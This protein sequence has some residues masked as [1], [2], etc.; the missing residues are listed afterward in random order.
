MWRLF[1]GFVSRAGEDKKTIELADQLKKTAKGK[2]DIYG[3]IS[4]IYRKNALSLGYLGLADAS[5][6]DFKKAISFAEEIKNNDRKM[7]LLSF[8][9]ENINSYYENKER[10]ELQM[11]LC[12]L[13]IR[14]ALK[15]LK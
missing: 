1:N 4:G 3:Y 6:E 12:L 10:R 2:K 14:K 5:L 13:I 8:A 15:W 9:Y 11:T 7:K